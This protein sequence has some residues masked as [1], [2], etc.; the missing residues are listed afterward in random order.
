MST[1]VQQIVDKYQGSVPQRVINAV[2]K[3]ASATGADFSQLMEKAAT[4]SGFNA[5]AKS[6]TS[7]ATGLFQFIDSTWL[8]MVKEHGAQLGLGQYADQIHMKDGKPCVADCTV[9]NA[10][11]NL[12]KNPE[13]SAMMAGMASADDRNYLQSHTDGPV[14]GTEMYLAHFMGAGGAAKF[15]NARADNGSASAA[16]VFP[17]EAHANKG[18]FYNSTTGHARTLD[19]VYNLLA[20][21]MGD[22]QVV[23][24]NNGTSDSQPTDSVGVS[25]ATTAPAPSTH[26]PPPSDGMPLMPGTMAQALP[27]SDDGIIW[28]SPATTARSG[29]SHSGGFIPGQKLSSNSILLLAQMQQHHTLDGSKNKTH[30]NA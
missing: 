16:Q 27:S 11:L 4:E 15:L 26:S 6:S 17:K 7:S 18:I 1:L 21:K 22:T 25:S 14:G 19:Q 10:I 28:D 3:A 8:G 24:D 13:I 9:K 20:R 12:R 29:F 5:S 23:E 30:Y 2:E